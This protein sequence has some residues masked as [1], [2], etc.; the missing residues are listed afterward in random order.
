MCNDFSKDFTNSDTLNLLIIS[1]VISTHL[2]WN[3]YQIN[4]S[5]HSWNLL[6]RKIYHEYSIIAKICA[7]GM[8]N[9]SYPISKFGG[10]NSEEFVQLHILRLCS[11]W[12]L[13]LLSKLCSFETLI[14]SSRFICLKNLP[15]SYPLTAT[16][17][18]YMCHIIILVLGAHSEKD[19]CY[20]HVLWDSW[21]SVH[22][23]SVSLNKSSFEIFILSRIT[24]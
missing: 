21:L 18:T 7:V 11:F 3:Q 14:I 1:T 10:R 6:H 8:I 13:K 20:S 24:F 4:Q 12:T 15:A 23:N 22:I 19:L 9:K 5:Q 17:P 2:K 16:K